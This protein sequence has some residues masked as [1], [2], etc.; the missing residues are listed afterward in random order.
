M[1]WNALHTGTRGRGVDYNMV[2][3]EWAKIESGRI[4]HRPAL[5]N[6]RALEIRNFYAPS[7]AKQNRP[8]STMDLIMLVE[9]LGESCT[10]SDRALNWWISKSAADGKSEDSKV[11]GGGDNLLDPCRSR[12]WLFCVKSSAAGQAAESGQAHTPTPQQ[13][14]SQQP[15][16]PKPTNLALVLALLHSPTLVSPSSF[17]RLLLQNRSTSHSHGISSLQSHPVSG[18]N[19]S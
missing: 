10:E 5:Q 17:Y 7:V 6:R 8:E 2:R 16:K 1:R 13:P 9:L 3:D 18:R 14:I 19:H 15:I 4:D 12:F 11:W